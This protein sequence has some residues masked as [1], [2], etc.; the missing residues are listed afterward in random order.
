MDEYD[1]FV[2]EWFAAGGEAYTQAYNDCYK[3]VESI[4][5]EAAN[6]FK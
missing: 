6:I 3:N 1:A 4:M 5:A 2:E